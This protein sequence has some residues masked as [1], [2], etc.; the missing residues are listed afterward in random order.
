MMFK[1]LLR[2]PRKKE[3]FSL[4]DTRTFYYSTHPAHSTSGLR[5][6]WHLSGPESIWSYQ[7]TGDSAHNV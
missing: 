6:R 2:K 1:E 4:R 7:G 5:Y 3:P